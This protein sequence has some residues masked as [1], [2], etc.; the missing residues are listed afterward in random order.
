MENQLG[1]IMLL[2]QQNRLND[3]ETMLKDL[4]REHPNNTTLLGMLA[5]VNLRQDK[6]ALAHGIITSAIGLAPDQSHLYLVKAFIELKY[7]KYDVAEA[8]LKHAIEYDPASDQAFALWANIKLVRKQYEDSLNLANKAL[9]IDATNKLALN[10]RST[11]LLKLGRSEESSET[12][13]GALSE[14]PH[15]AFTHATYGWNLLEKGSHNKALDHFRE[16]LRIDPNLRTAQE[17][18]AEALKAK[19]FVYRMFLK[20]S[21]W[22]GKMS[23]NYQWGFIIGLYLAYRFIGWWADNSPEMQPFLYPLLVVL[24]IV[25]FSTWVI[26]PISNLFLRLNPYGKHLLNKKEKMSSNFVGISFA[27]FILGLL[28]YLINSDMRFLPVAAFGFAMMLPLGVMFAPTKQ[29]NSLIYYTIAMCAVG[30]MSIM[31]TFQTGEIF[32]MYST[33]F[34]IGFIGFQW[35]ANF[36]IIRQ[37]NV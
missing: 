21:F 25:A 16:A 29:K 18:M 33:I 9:E 35:V 10:V 36:L 14:D 27:I 26:N 31:N 12:I 37:S 23:Q 30:I 13:E 32:S 11:A 15:D 28:L 34:T 22:L 4:L 8:D 5:E 20:Y 7:D 1:R 24:A 19:S 3:A 2:M 6:V 17:G